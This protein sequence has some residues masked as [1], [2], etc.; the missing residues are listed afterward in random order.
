MEKLFYG[1]SKAQKHFLVQILFAASFTTLTSGTFLSGLAVLMGA[2]DVLVSYISVITN[3]CGIFV[4][5]FAA[6]LERSQNQK[7]LAI[8]LTFLS[9]LSTFSIILIP[10]CVERHLQLYLFVPIIL[11]AFTLQG[12]S[13][14]ALNN[15]LI[16]YTPSKERGRYISIRQTISLII[17]VVSSVLAGRYLDSAPSQYL[18]FAIIFLVALAMAIGE[19]IVLL[20]ID[21]ANIVSTAKEKFSFKD[22]FI[23]SIRN[24]RFLRYVIIILF[25]YLF[26]YISDS[27]TFIFMF[28]YLGLPYTTITVLQML[29][30]LPQIFLLSVWGKI[31]DKFGHKFV[32]NISIWLFIG[33]TFFLFLTTTS[34]WMFSIPIAFLI[35]SI[36]NSGFVLSLFNRRYEIIPE[37]KRI[38]YDSF[39]NAIIGIAFIAGPFLG[40]IIRNFI[41]S[42]K[43]LQNTMEFPEIRLLY[44]IST[45]GILCLQ[46]FSF[47]Q[48]KISK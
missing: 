31:S 47:L 12:L 32:L 28:K 33:E 27:F 17:T 16:F 13:T 22:T 39:F 2:N 23:T 18:G 7:R 48:K 25:F 1:Y 14:V 29:I 35:A 21:E 40:G 45:I 3:I 46:L 24:K 9:K 10:L 41:I 11:V 19:I 36:A 5:M 20:R 30:T 8:G 44:A 34:N 26:L 43:I 15:W 6:R 38:L 42:N 37:E 4:L